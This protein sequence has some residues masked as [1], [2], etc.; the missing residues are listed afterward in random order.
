MTYNINGQTK[1]VVPSFR[2]LGVPQ[3]IMFTK[4]HRLSICAVFFYVEGYV[5]LY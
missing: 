4:E 1:R 5:A 2:L 3:S